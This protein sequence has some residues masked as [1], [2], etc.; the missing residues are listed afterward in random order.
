MFFDRLID[1][2][3]LCDA[4][5]TSAWWRTCSAWAA[6]C[7][8][9]LRI[10]RLVCMPCFTRSKGDGMLDAAELDPWKPPN[11]FCGS[12]HVSGIFRFCQRFELLARNGAV[13]GREPVAPAWLPVVLQGML[14]MESS[15]TSETGIGMHLPNSKL[16]HKTW[17][18]NSVPW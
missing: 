6:R 8:R 12:R 4:G 1:S 14:H 2:D 3:R 7:A 11:A 9:G 5:R 15:R 13:A 17:S 18:L 10:H 16:Q